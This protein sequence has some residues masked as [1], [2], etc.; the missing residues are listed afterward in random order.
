[1]DMDE[2]IGTKPNNC[3]NRMKRDGVRASHDALLFSN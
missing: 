2:N 1:M 3:V